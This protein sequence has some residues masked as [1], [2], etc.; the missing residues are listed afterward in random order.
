MNSQITII[1]KVAEDLKRQT[2]R[3]ITTASRAFLPLRISNPV[4]D[5]LGCMFGILDRS[6]VWQDG[7]SL[8]DNMEGD[9]RNPAE[10]P[11]NQ[12]CPSA[13]DGIL[14][15]CLA[16]ERESL[17]RDYAECA[18]GGRLIEWAS[19][20]LSLL[21]TETTMSG[22]TRR[23]EACAF[24]YQVLSRLEGPLALDIEDAELPFPYIITADSFLGLEPREI[25]A[26]CTL[27]VLEKEDGRITIMA[28]TKGHDGQVYDLAVL[29]ATLTNIGMESGRAENDPGMYL[30][31]ESVFFL[32]EWLNALSNIKK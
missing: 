12:L 16:A 11:V 5:G 29:C 1:R 8:F 21:G 31:D 6:K 30:P 22:W 26:F 28:G 7:L 14:R 3:N 13:L 20:A 15:D 18:E 24:I 32:E 19:D 10:M 17:V 2:I 27:E 9:F 25:A 23:T 4:H